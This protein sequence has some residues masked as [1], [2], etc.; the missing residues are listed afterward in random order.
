MSE[1]EVQPQIQPETQTAER[2]IDALRTELHALLEA[3]DVRYVNFWD[4]M[5]QLIGRKKPLSK[6]E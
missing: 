6:A 4:R 2:Q 1:H 5:Q 3:Y